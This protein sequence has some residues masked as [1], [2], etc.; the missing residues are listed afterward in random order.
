MTVCEEKCHGCKE[1]ET[2]GEC[3]PPMPTTGLPDGIIA[4]PPVGESIESMKLHPDLVE[5]GRKA[6]VMDT[7][8]SCKSVLSIGYLYGA[9][10]WTITDIMRRVFEGR[11]LTE[12]TLKLMAN[13]ETPVIPRQK[14]GI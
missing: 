8:D 12:A 5:M 13:D 4:L 14:E 1:N 10:V 7:L 2:G 9:E 3:R 6:A 11:T